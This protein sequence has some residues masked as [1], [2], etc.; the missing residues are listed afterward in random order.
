ML[1]DDM[2][3]A[4]ESLFKNEN[5][6]DPEW[7]PKLLP[8]RD[9]QQRRVA[10]CIKPILIDRNG[11]NAFVFGAPGIGKTAAAKWVLRDLADSEFGEKIEM[12]YVNCWQK[13]TT[14]KVYAELCSQFGYS[15]TQNKSSEELLDL[16]KEKCNKRGA[17]FVFDE[18]DKAV[19]ND[20]IYSLLNDVFKKSI[21][22]ITNDPEWIQ[23]IEDRV[24]SRLLP[25]IIEFKA[26]SSDETRRILKDRLDY[27]F[28]LNSF[29]DEAFEIVCTAAS[30]IFDIRVG[31]H[32]LRQSGLIAESQ[33][34][35]QV[36]PIHAEKALLTLPDFSPKKKDDL[37]EDS[38]LILSV[39]KSNSGEKI[40]RLFEL[41]QQSGGKGIY[42]TFQRRIEK[43]ASNKFVFAEKV[44]GKEGNTTI[45]RYEKPADDVKA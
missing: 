28:V 6:L 20:F 24:K 13:N 15:F 35:R 17:V 21:I 12:F 37:E 41:Y 38:Q 23:D 31:L 4:G 39:V 30:K 10:E 18:M 29:S 43:L 44:T 45:V 25:E 14:F 34:S 8:F 5:A 3:K 9:S 1:F 16:I 32:L 2:L 11:R 33:S 7:V 22:L 40:G 27:A 36:L 19:D 26:Y 42:K